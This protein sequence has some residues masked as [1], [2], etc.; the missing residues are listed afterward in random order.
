ME[1]DRTQYQDY[2]E[3]LKDSLDHDEAMKFAIGDGG[4]NAF[5]I[6][7]R[8]LLIHYGLKK[9]DYLIEIG[10]GSGRLASKLLTYLE[11]KYRKVS[12]S[13]GQSFQR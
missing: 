12:T 3:S 4:F 2:V 6:M 1:V 13:Y 5:G 8:D 7:Q 10:C 11:G 9:N